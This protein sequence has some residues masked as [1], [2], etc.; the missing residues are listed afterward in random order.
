MIYKSIMV[1]NHVGAIACMGGVLLL[2]T[3][4]SIAALFVYEVLAGLASPGLFAIPQIFA[5]PQAAG[6]WV[7]VH[8]TV[9]GI[10]GLVAPAVTGILV[11]RSG[12]FAL[13][14]G[15]AAAVSAVGLIAWV[16]VLPKVAPVKWQV[17]A[18]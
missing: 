3:T 15:L 16:F 6:R 7:G 17:A 1:L 11:D 18:A 8:N 13:A 10:A 2:P 4:G 9:G 5:G 14:F 12:Q